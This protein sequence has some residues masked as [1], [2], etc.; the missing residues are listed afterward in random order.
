LRD[1]RATPGRQSR[2]RY[3]SLDI[4]P[5]IK[6]RLEATREIPGPPPKPK[7]RLT[8]AIKNEMFIAECR[9]NLLENFHELYRCFDKGRHGSPTFD[10]AGYQLD[11]GKVQDW[12]RPQAYNKARMVRNMDRSLEKTRS[13]E[14]KM[15]ETFFVEKPDE[16]RWIDIDGYVKDQ[17]SKDIGIPW[18]QIGPR[19]VNM[20]REKGFNPVVFEEWWTEPTAEEH[21]RFMK[22]MGGA[23]L[24]KHL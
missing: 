16:E 18:H 1:P 3:T 21:K 5:D 11:F 2:P 13:D 9:E 6:A 23:S 22:M 20:W 4:A 24:R 7:G 19:E 8:K 12:M 17:V 10:A 15:F 14:E